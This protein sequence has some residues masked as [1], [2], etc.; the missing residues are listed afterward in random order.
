VRKEG[1]RIRSYVHIGTGNYH[2]KTAR[3]YE[4]FGLLTCDPEITRDVV[5]LFHY[6]TGHAEAPDCANLLVAPYTMRQRFQA[7]ILREIDNRKAGKPARIVAK[8]NQLEDS[9]M[10]GLLCQA[11]TAGVAIDL[12]VRGF[13]CLRP[14]VRGR[15]ENIRVRSIVGRFLEHSRVF[16]FA[17]GSE[18][19]L[20]GEFFIGSAD[21]MY[22]NLAK[23]IEVI[24]PVRAV[25]AKAKLWEV[26][27]LCLKDQRQ[28]WELNS[29][30]HYTRLSPAEDDLSQAVG[31]HQTLMQRSLERN[32]Q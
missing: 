31:I 7:L 30:G 10:I 23:R 25:H 4:D 14:G 3:L 20:E 26:L 28:A 9:G 12:I 19:P 5:N 2:V 32:R 24:T 22:R 21:W 17:N 13:C 29:D 27:G 18:D 15:T 8:M 16:Y 1:T 11:S 6:L